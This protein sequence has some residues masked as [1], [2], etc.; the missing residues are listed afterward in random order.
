MHGTPWAD[1]TPGI[2]QRP[3]QPGKSFTHRFRATQY[4]SYWYHSHFAAQISDGLYGAI[5]I[6]PRSSDPKPFHLISAN[7]ATLLA[8]E[9]AERNVRP[10]VMAEFSHLTSEE[11]SE[12]AHKSGIEVS[13]YDSIM[14]NGKGSAQCLPEDEMAALI[15]EERRFYLDAVP[16]ATLTDKG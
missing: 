10:L 14:F 5:I 11:R 13:C 3:I 16:G 15:N 9:E 12:F 7:P 6:H 8:L 4:G 1:G 2:V